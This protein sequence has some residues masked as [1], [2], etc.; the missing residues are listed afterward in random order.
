MTSPILMISNSQTSSNSMSF[1]RQM[2]CFLPF[3]KMDTV[4][5]SAPLHLF[6]VNDDNSMCYANAGG[7]FLMSYWPTVFKGK[8]ECC[9]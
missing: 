8:K 9:Y 4:R 3:L 2:V 5:I 7:G 1:G 6:G